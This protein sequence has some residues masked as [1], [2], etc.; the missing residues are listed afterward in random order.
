MSGIDQ[1]VKRLKREENFWNGQFHR[2]IPLIKEKNSKQIASQ[3]STQAG[4]IL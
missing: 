4:L 1:L 2:I 3:T